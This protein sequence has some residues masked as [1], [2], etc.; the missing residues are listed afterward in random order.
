VSL[1]LVRAEGLM[2]SLADGD[3]SARRV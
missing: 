3:L 2:L 1:K